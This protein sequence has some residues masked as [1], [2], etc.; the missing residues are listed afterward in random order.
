MHRASI[1]KLRLRP[2][3]NAVFDSGVVFAELLART[4]R[5][6][7]SNVTADLLGVDAAQV[8][9]WKYGKERITQTSYERLLDLDYVL[10]RVLQ[11]FEADDAGEWLSSPSPW[12]HGG[13]PLDVLIQEGPAPVIDALSAVE[14]GAFL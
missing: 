12:L 14:E 2:Q 10:N 4:T 6:L 7:G 9:R 11:V 8:S 1:A 5:A 3:A 13:R